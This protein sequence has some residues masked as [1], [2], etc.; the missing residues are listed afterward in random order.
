MRA[1]SRR[2]P[3]AGG[4][5]QHGLTHWPS[6]R[7]QTGLRLPAGVSLPLPQVLVLVPRQDLPRCPSLQTQARQVKTLPPPPSSPGPSL[8]EGTY[9]GRCAHGVG[10][11][12][13]M[14]QTGMGVP[15]GFQ[16]S[17]G[18]RARLDRVLPRRL[19][20]DQPP[21][22]GLHVWPPDC[23]LT[24]VC[25][26]AAQGGP[27]CA[28]ALGHAHGLHQTLRLPSFPCCPSQRSR[29]LGVG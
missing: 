10:K 14:T 17:P 25:S 8:R 18:R 24:G 22:P 7:E 16:A 3:G 23:G 4:R 2:A 13:G 1:E 29:H 28:A 9:S 19:G 6:A 27:F 5:Q 26:E 15:R 12:H 20:R 11:G 21:T